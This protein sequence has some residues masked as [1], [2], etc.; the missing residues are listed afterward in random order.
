MQRNF[1][2]KISILAVASLALLAV[3]QCLWVAN[4]YSK[5]KNDFI[6]RVES[7]AYKSIYKAFRMDAIP[8]LETTE[9]IE[10]DLNKFA[11]HFTP[12]L[13]ELDITEPYTA[14]ILDL[15][16]D[17][18]V[19]MQYGSINAL[20][21][22]IHTSEIII[23]D[24][25][26]FSLRLNINYPYK[27]F[28]GRMWGLLASSALIVVLLSG[29]LYYLVKTM[30]RQRS[31]EQMRQD[32]TH[33]ITHEL[34]TPISVAT[35]ATDALRNFSAEADVERRSRYLEIVENQLSQLGGM[36]ERILSVSVEGEDEKICKERI[37]LAPIISEIVEQTKMSISIPTNF[38]VECPQHLQIYA[39]PFHLKNVLATLTGNAVK[40]SGKGENTLI[41]IFATEEKGWS[42]I[43]VTDNGKGITKEHLTH[44]FEKFYRVPQGDIQQARGY[45]L[46]LY[47]AHKVIVLHGGTI[48]AKSHI[49]QGCEFTIL[50]PGE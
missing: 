48:N 5:Q 7:A 21:S 22:K 9:M 2:K 40:Y 24:D 44:I 6:R 18:R 26:I 17:K 49:G 25:S 34:K 31:I 19:L 43:S 35:A 50:L 30:F 38:R 16:S 28:W 37:T 3:V 36:V 29:V 32:F 4:M 23:D 46:G 42:R 11:L 39:D 14:E 8:G 33:N 12:N 47:Y 13:M 15:T 10:I 27:T 20:G 41:R 1:F 45:G